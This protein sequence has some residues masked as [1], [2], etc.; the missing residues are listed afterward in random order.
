MPTY[1]IYTRMNACSFF[2]TEMMMTDDCV[3][4]V[5]SLVKMTLPK[6]LGCNVVIV[7]LILYYF[8]E[9]QED[10]S[11]VIFEVRVRTTVICNDKLQLV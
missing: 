3:A 2:L 10:N 11:P 7:I 9:S 4:Y 8:V 6:T 1:I 5:R